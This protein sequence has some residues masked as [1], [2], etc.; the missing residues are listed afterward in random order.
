MSVLEQRWFTGTGIEITDPIAVIGKILEDEPGLAIRIGTDAQKIGNGTEFVTVVVLYR[1]RRGGRMFWARTRG[2]ERMSL[3]EKLSMET[4]LSLEMAMALEPVV[5]AGREQM[6]VHID[7]NPV[8]GNSS[9]SYHKQLAGMIMGQGFKAVLKPD[10]WVSSHA[11]DHIVKYRHL[12]ST[13]RRRERRK[14]RTA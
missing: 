14:R 12:S 9:H 3:W 2:R 7:A 8:E 4:W 1:E 10:A 13:A 11:A 6:E 5:P